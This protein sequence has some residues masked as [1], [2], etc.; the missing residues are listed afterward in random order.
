M[1]LFA[2]TY[3]YVLYIVAVKILVLYYSYTII[4][5]YTEIKTLYIVNE[6]IIQ[7]GIALCIFLFLSFLDYHCIETSA[8]T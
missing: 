3:K 7:T 8:D 2:Y 1:I 5:V 6:Y 4:T